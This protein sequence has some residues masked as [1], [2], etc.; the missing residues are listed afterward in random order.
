MLGA[1]SVAFHAKQLR[2]RVCVCVCVC[3]EVVAPRHTHTHSSHSLGDSGAILNSGSSAHA[4][5]QHNNGSIQTSERSLRIHPVSGLR[6]SRPAPLASLQ[7]LI[8]RNERLIEHMY[9]RAHLPS[10]LEAVINVVNI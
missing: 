7:S 5:A 4:S 1:A 10:F 8:K 6:T 9:L 3:M 2:V